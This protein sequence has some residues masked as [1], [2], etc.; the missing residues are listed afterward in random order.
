[1]FISGDIPLPVP[2]TNLSRSLCT[3]LESVTHGSTI[4]TCTFPK[5]GRPLL[6]FLDVASLVP[7]VD[8][9]L[10]LGILFD[11]LMEELRLFSF[12]A[13]ILIVIHVPRGIFDEIRHVLKII[14]FFLCFCVGCG[15]F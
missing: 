2:G 8:S 13:I 1:M 12:L 7:T 3:F 9:L 10:L 4:C 6:C 11:P 15:H 14:I 5:L